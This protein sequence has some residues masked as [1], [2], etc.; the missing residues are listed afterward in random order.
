MSTK[1]KTKTDITVALVNNLIVETVSVSV[2]D[3]N[4]AWV[5]INTDVI[6]TKLPKNEYLSLKNSEYSMLTSYLSSIVVPLEE[7]IAALDKL[8][9]DAEKL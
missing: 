4:N 3:V 5:I 9:K 7:D 2:K 8:I 6:Q 1:V